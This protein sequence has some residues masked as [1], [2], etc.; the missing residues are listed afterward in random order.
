MNNYRHFGRYNATNGLTFRTHRFQDIYNSLTVGRLETRAWYLQAQ[1]DLQEGG[2]DGETA[3]ELQAR[4]TQ[5]LARPE[6]SAEDF[7]YWE[8]VALYNRIV[9]I[10]AH[11]YPGNCFD[12]EAYLLDRDFLL[13]QVGNETYA[14]EIAACLDRLGELLAKI[15]RNQPKRRTGI[16]GRLQA[17]FS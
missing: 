17:L 5:A 4:I 6:V 9:E 11:I 14:L 13:A 1:R 15:E 8:N 3:R 7:V 16:L 2:F 12:E 10:K